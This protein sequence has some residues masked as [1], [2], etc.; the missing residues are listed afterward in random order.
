MHIHKARRIEKPLV[1]QQCGKDLSQFPVDIRNCPYCGKA[2]P[3]REANAIPIESIEVE[4]PESIQKIRRYAKMTAISGLLIAIASFILGPFLGGLKGPEHTYIAPILHEYGHEI[5]YGVVAGVSIAISSAIV[6][7]I[8]GSLARSQIARGGELVLRWILGIA[9]ILLPVTP[10]FFGMHFFFDWYAPGL[11][12]AVCLLVPK[13]YSMKVSI[14]LLALA[15]I[16]ALWPRDVG[17][18][19]PA[20]SDAWLISIAFSSSAVE[21]GLGQIV[22]FWTLLSEKALA[23]MAGILLVAKKI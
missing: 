7:V 22:N 20:L 23:V 11:L 16:F 9:M 17:P 15:L 21:W 5:G 19:G 1:C 10:T 6:Q 2:I 4:F 14:I 13:R 12:I 18:F 8:A 3:I